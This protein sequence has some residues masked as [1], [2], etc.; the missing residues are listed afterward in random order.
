VLRFQ[1]APLSEHLKDER[2]G[3]QRKSESDD[4]GRRRRQACEI[5]GAPQEQRAQED[6]GGAESEYDSPHDP[7]AGR[8]QFQT[9]D[10]QQQHHAELRDLRDVLDI[11]DE[12]QAPGPDD[13]ARSDVTENRAEPEEPEHRY[14]QH[15]GGQQDS[16]L[17]E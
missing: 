6:L 10:E 12:P 17:G 9:N 1:L 2:S 15:G 4:G 11:A 8:L 7:Q 14:G 13:E 3:G 16:G 5:S